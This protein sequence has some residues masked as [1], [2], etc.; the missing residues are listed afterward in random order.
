M[1]STM[2][3]KIT[4]SERLKD[5]REGMIRELQEAMRRENYY[6]SICD[7]EDPAIE[8]AIYDGMAR[9]QA[10]AA[11]IEHTWPAE[12]RWS[13]SNGQY[14]K[15]TVERLYLSEGNAARKTTHYVQTYRAHDA[16][17]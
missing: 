16:R 14:T 4:A 5:L 11:M 9:V 15:F 8:G 6:H 12:I 17:V 13:L 2:S 3:G 10:I 7:H 1:P